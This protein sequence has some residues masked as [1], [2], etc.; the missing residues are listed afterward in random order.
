MFKFEGMYTHFALNNVNAVLF[1]FNS[2]LFYA[3]HDLTSDIQ[4]LAYAKMSCT[5]I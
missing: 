2:S 1:T 4:L 3:S 5:F